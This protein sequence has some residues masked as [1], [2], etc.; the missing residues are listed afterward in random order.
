MEQPSV[1]RLRLPLILL[2]ALTLQRSLLLDLQLGNIHPDLLLLVTICVAATAGS[3][4]G[5]IVGFIAGLLA[6]LFAQTPFGLSALTYSL[7]AFAVGALQAG[8][9]RSTWWITPLTAMV[10][11][12]VAVV[13]FA[14]L[15]AVIGQTHFMRV[16][17]PVVALGAAVI[18]G[19]LSIPVARLVTWATPTAGDG[20][21]AR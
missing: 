18:N 10:A 15:G 14:V 19:I 2:V 16:D 4:L 20:A 5:A 1:T 6:D 21:F 8:L 9:I 12:A 3:E 17:I 7:V 11:S 13:L